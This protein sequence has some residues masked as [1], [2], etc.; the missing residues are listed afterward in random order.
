[1]RVNALRLWGMLVVAFLAACASSTPPT[2]G[3]ERYMVTAMHTPFYRYG[4]AQGVGADAV[5]DNGTHL[6]LLYRSYG[7]SRVMLESG[8]SGYVGTDAIAALPP[9]PKPV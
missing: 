3:N 4:P 6:P 8:I 1:M 7:Y 9:A 5:L 2:P